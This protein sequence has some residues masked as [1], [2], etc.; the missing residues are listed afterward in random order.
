[1]SAIRSTLVRAGVAVTA[2][3]LCLVTT[4]LG[5]SAV[6]GPDAPAAT[7]AGT[8]KASV[9]LAGPSSATY[10][11]T[12]TLTGTAWRT[13]TTTKLV[14]ATI[15]LQRA[16]HGGSTWSNVTST[17]TSST[18]T[19]AFNVK[20]T[21]PYDYR[22]RYGGSATYTVAVSPRIFPIVRQNV[23]FDSIRDTNWE[24]GTMQV[25]GRIYPAPAKG[26]RVWLQR[27]NATSKAWSNFMSTV[28]TGTNAFLMKGNFAGNVGTYRIYAPQHGYYAYNYSRQ[29]TF[30]HYKWRGAFTK[31]AS[32]SPTGEAYI[33]NATESPARDEL[34]MRVQVSAGAGP[35]TV[36]VSSQGCKSTRLAAL[37]FTNEPGQTPATGRFGALNG[38]TYVRG[39]WTLG[40]GASNSGSASL[41]NVAALTLKV[42]R[43]SGADMLVYGVVDLLCSN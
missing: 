8:T 37:N 28:S 13:G 43:I 4:A 39:P 10:G 20:L 29:V 42:D 31:P 30:A 7:A 34:E 11:T 22:A 36:V 25:G 32:I 3:G 6:T 14:N 18:G 23:L 2:A 19:F 33:Y 16:T 12:V 40:P 17:H 1:M 9:S 15:W 41:S 21:T 26:T 38:S 24:L 5:A 35:T 27:Y